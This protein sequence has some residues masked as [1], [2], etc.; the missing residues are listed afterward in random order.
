MAL[1]DIRIKLKSCRKAAAAEEKSFLCSTIQAS[2]QPISP[3]VLHTKTIY[4]S[5]T[6]EKERNEL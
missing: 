5:I 4:Y 2:A 6:K 1:D 3:C